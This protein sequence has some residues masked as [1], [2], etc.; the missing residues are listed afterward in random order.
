MGI[1]QSK[2]S[3]CNRCVRSKTLSH[4]T[5]LYP[6]ALETCIFTVFRL[7]KLPGFT[8]W[9][10]KTCGDL[11][12]E[13][14]NHSKKNHVNTLH[15]FSSSFFFINQLGQKKNKNIQTNY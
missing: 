5:I 11:N 7:N 2:N 8:P 9:F 10:G 15:F 1:L 3:N 13:I 4:Y 6:D 12:N 14:S